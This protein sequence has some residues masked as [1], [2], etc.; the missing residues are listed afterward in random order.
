MEDI[1][2]HVYGVRGDS[3]NGV[4]SMKS[5]D[6]FLYCVASDGMGWEHVSVSL[7]ESPRL[8][9]I[10]R[11]PTWEEMCLVKNRFWDKDDTVMQLHP[12]EC[13]YVN[14][15][16]YCLHLWKP[17][18]DLVDAGADIP[19]PNP[20]MV[21]IAASWGKKSKWERIVKRIKRRLSLC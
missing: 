8:G 11:C 20:V 2:L 17:D 19:L 15:Q 13:D 10:K 5:G 9:S 12:P 21:G 7:R 3:R 18:R 6:V 1:E 14:Q 16:P 4:F